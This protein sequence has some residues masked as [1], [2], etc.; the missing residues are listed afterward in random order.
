MSSGYSAHTVYIVASESEAQ[1]VRAGI[2]EGNTIR[3]SI[4]ESLLSDEVLVAMSDDVGD[5]V[6]AA[7]AAANEILATQYGVE[8]RIVDLR[9]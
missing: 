2:G 7:E 1:S 5:S 8:N 4:G 9:G 3:A 6:V